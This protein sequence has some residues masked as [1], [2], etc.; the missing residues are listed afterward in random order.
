MNLPELIAQRVQSS[1]ARVGIAVV[2]VSGE[3]GFG[4]REDDVFLQASAIKIPILWALHDAAVRGALSLDETLPID[5]TNGTGGCGVLQHFASS[6]TRLALGDLAVLMIVLSDNV[7][8]NH[9]IDRLGFDAINQL[10]QT[11]VEGDV[12]CLRRKMY[13]HAARAAG[14]ENTASPAAAAEMMVRLAHEA[15]AGMGC[16]NA[17]LRTLRLKK[18][19]P[20]TAALDGVAALATKPGML[21][22][23]RTEWSIVREGSGAYAMVLM[24]DGASD[25]QLEPLFHDLAKEIHGAMGV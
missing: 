14:I 23:V 22:N 19:S 11:K 17:V 6:A 7:A 21:D 20:V 15:A 10:I 3:G 1:A 24:A 16:A 4:I 12:I 8:T 9:L 13:D 2:P 18:T 5:P 25:K